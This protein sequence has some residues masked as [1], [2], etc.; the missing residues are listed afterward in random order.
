M[1]IR[2]RNQRQSSRLNA[3]ETTH[4][5][6]TWIHNTRTGT[7]QPD[8]LQTSS[9]PPHLGV[10]YLKP[11]RRPTACCAELNCPC[12]PTD[13][14]GVTAWLYEISMGPVPTDSWPEQLSPGAPTKGDGGT[15]IYP[16]SSF[17]CTHGTKP[18]QRRGVRPKERGGPAH[19]SSSRGRVRHV[20]S[21]HVTSRQV[22][23][24]HVTTSKRE[25]KTGAVWRAHACL[26]N[27]H[28]KGCTR[29]T[30]HA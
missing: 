1:Y 12:P 13:S 22:T 21:A 6:K 7:N 4:Q 29:S 25:K 30:A 20:T 19:T 10:L 5:P 14:C 11:Y 27:E 15:Y 23:P 2:R 24:R 3:H 26:G 18:N 17:G 8:D 9:P 28:G 16:T